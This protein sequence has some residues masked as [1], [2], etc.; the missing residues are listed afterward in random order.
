MP[1]VDTLDS[2]LALT[3]YTSL[4]HRSRWTVGETNPNTGP[5]GKWGWEAKITDLQDN[6]ALLKIVFQCNTVESLPTLEDFF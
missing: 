6:V 2:M 3:R 4:G 1:C 5:H